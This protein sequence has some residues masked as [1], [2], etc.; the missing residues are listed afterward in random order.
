MCSYL[1]PWIFC[2]QGLGGDPVGDHDLRDPF[3][4]HPGAHHAHALLSC[5]QAVQAV[6][7]ELEP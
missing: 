4:G 3:Q 2:C 5:D 6:E 7:A 1:G